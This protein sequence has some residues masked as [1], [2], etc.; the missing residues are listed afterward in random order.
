M[1]R[2]HALNKMSM[3]RDVSQLTLGDLEGVHYHLVVDCLPSRLSCVY[4]SI[5]MGYFIINP[6][7]NK[8]PGLTGTFDSG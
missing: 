7:I 4:G 6:Y 3:W 5:M 2:S 1:F 8:V